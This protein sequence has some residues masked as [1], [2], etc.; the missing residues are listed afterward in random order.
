MMIRIE[1][2]HAKIYEVASKE[3][4]RYVLNGVFIDT[5]NQCAVATDGR[6]LVKVPTTTCEQ[7]NGIDDPKPFII[8]TED[9]KRCLKDCKRSKWAFIALW[10][11]ATGQIAWEGGFAT[12]IDGKFP[13]YSQ[14]LPKALPDPFTV[15]CFNPDMMAKLKKALTAKKDV[16]GVMVA[17]NEPGDPIMVGT[18][19]SEALAVLMPMRPGTK[20]KA[21][22]LY[23]RKFEIPEDRKDGRE[24]AFKDRLRREWP[25]LKERAVK[26]LKEAGW[27]ITPPEP[28]ETKPQDQPDPQMEVAEA[29]LGVTKGIAE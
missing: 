9:W 13:N 4:T 1:W 2:D 22:F 28:V 10:I 16:Q 21:G 23:G 24:K 27:T 26:Q 20:D 6:M 8:G 17:Q 7:P 18:S 11:N 14:V 29:M 3:A 19:D 5:E 12:P 15:A 25:G